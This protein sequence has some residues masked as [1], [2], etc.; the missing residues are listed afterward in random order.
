[1]AT[2]RIDDVLHDAMAYHV[3]R[4]ELDEHE[5]VDVVQHVAYEE[6]PGAMLAVSLSADE[7]RP[8]LGEGVVIA[9]VNT[10][11]QTVVAGEAGAVAA[12]QTVLEAE[13]TR[14]TRLPVATAFHSPLVAAA[15]ERLTAWLRGQTLVAPR[16]P[17][18]ATIDLVNQFRLPMRPLEQLPTSRDRYALGIRLAK[19]FLK[20]NA[21]L[22][23]DQRMYYDS[24]SIL[25]TTTDARWVQDVGKRLRVWPHVRVNAQTGA[26]FYKLAYSAFL[27]SDGS[28]SLPL[29]RSD[30]REL[31]PLITLTGGGGLRFAL[32]APDSKTQVGLNMAG[33]LMYTRFF[34]AL[35]V[36]TRTAVYG[37]VGV[38]FEFD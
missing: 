36:T 11:E 18:G 28:I 19:R 5:A 4:S 31:G 27:N 15:G 6:Q 30:D 38:D 8:R 25:S 14:C 34:D 2:V 16:I 13:G 22:R 24:W 9:N 29:F 17:V 21:T 20:F 32:T 7:I 12:L 33:D 10:P 23:L 1:M 37:T 35:F 3:A 26:S